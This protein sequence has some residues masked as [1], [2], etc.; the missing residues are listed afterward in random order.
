MQNSSFNNFLSD[1]K[2]GFAELTHGSLFSGIGGF[3]LA[4]AWSGIETIWNCEYEQWNRE[5]L[6]KN[7]PSTKQYED[8]RTMRNAEKVGIISGGFPCQDISVAGKGVGIKGSRSGLWGE[9]WR[10]IREVRPKYVI[11]ENSPAL[12]I[13]GFE[14]VLCDLS[15][16]GYDAEWQCLRA[17]DFGYPHQRERLFCIAYPSSFSVQA[18]FKEHREISA[19]SKE[20]S[21]H[22]S[23][24]MSVE[25]VDG[26]TDYRP[27]TRGDGVSDYVDRTKAMGNAI[28][29]M[30]AYY[31]FECIK[32]HYAALAA[33][34]KEEKIIKT[35]LKHEPSSYA[36]M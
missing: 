7:F 18:V 23:R 15:E 30:V 27:I 19:V 22:N 3:E 31:I 17:S 16:I 4:A 5:I 35:E 12:L 9:M 26:Q 13:R 32:N 36:E 6:F 25:W 21:G 1:G 29:P 10:I 24:F 2:N 20:A 28:V 33:G 14:R 8:V 11:I 34:A